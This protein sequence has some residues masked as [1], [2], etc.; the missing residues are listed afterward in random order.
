MLC[1]TTAGFKRDFIFTF[2]V[3]LP[4]FHIVNTTTVNMWVSVIILGCL[5][6][7]VQGWKS[8]LEFD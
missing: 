5:L 6:P 4:E 7:G 3:P 2:C 1:S 8:F